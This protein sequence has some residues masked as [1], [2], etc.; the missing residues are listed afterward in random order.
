MSWKNALQSLLVW[1][2][3]SSKG[4]WNSQC[5]SVI[6]LK[7]SLPPFPSQTAWA[8]A[9]SFWPC[10]H[11]HIKL[12]LA[13]T[14]WSVPISKG[15]EGLPPVSVCPSSLSSV[16]PSAHIGFTTNSGT[17]CPAG[18]SKPCLSSLGCSR[19]PTVM[20][21]MVPLLS[22][23]RSCSSCTFVHGKYFAHCSHD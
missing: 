9:S 19:T 12:H 3:S 22:H 23:L 20:V 18:A 15:P 16:W 2:S 10:L 5:L 21:V 8:T 7:R 13:R 17:A 4:F 11:S 6:T 14:L 1:F